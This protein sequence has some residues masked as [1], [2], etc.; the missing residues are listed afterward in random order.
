MERI[1]SQPIRVYFAGFES[2][3]L[4]MQHVGWELSAQENI[5]DL[6]MQVAFRHKQ[7]K[8]FALSD[9]I[10]FNYIEACDNHNYAKSTSLHIRN[11]AENIYFAVP[12]AFQESLST[13]G[14]INTTTYYRGAQT[15][16]YMPVNATPKYTDCSLDEIA[17]FNREP[18]NKI[19]VPEKQIVIPEQD[20]ESLLDQ[21][22]DKHK[23]TN[24]KYHEKM[25]SQSQPTKVAA[26]IISIAR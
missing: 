10:A 11:I 18:H 24:R 6:T 26:Q 3:T 20:I 16:A 2:D 22:L 15:P 4:R 5:H 13:S 9:K 8:I 14:N 1:L 17:F 25:Q 12:H 21:I 23:D 7:M 19:I